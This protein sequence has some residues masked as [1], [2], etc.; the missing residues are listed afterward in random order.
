M[1]Y[2][3]GRR[4]LAL[5]AA[6]ALATAGSAF[7]Q[8]TTDQPSTPAEA[9]TEAANVDTADQLAEGADDDAIVITAVARKRRR[10]WLISS[11]ISFLPLSGETP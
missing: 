8:D 11:T 1:R 4:E 7:A 6:L 5:V 2:L 10:P 3:P 9:P